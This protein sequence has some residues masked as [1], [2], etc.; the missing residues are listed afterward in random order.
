MDV[1]YVK[2]A[3]HY[4]QTNSSAKP[5]KGFKSLIRLFSLDLKI[6]KFQ[7]EYLSVYLL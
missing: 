5:T 1:K 7:K 4:P 6:V 2:Q 3:Y